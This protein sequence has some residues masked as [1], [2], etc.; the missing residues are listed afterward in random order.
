MRLVQL[1]PLSHSGFLLPDALGPNRDVLV[2]T[3]AHPSLEASL[4][5][6]ERS[7][8]TIA[9]LF[10]TH[11]HPDHVSLA[12]IHA[13]TQR[14]VTTYIGRASWTLLSR[15]NEPLAVELEAT[16]LIH[17]LPSAGAMMVESIDIAWATF[18]HGLDV[19]NVA[20]RVGTF[21]FSGDT[22]TSKLLAPERDDVRRLLSLD[23]PVVE[24][25]C[26]N[27]AQLSR[28]DLQAQRPTLGERAYRARL[29][30]H[31]IAEDL[32]DALGDPALRPFFEKLT[33]IVPHHIRRA[34]LDVSA[35][36]IRKELARER[37]VLGLSFDIAYPGAEG[38]HEVT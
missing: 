17:L 22:S 15:T 12:E 14:N 1:H 7:L 33:H 36:W 9:C 27:T 30:N 8:D 19:P 25:F 10:V 16:D 13:L 38:L 21:L 35:Q 24:T 29:Y 20:F 3:G 6:N 26:V 32:V 23:Q 18:P 4:A 34:P 28:A 2:D 37:D 31:G 5:A 11:H